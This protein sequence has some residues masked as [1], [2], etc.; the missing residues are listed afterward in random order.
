MRKASA[1]ALESCARALCI[2][3]QPVFEVQS[4]D[5]ACGPSLET[6]PMQTSAV[7]LKRSLQ[8]RIKMLSLDS[9]EMQ[10]HDCGLAE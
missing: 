8:Q 9:A 6:G 10:A 7:Q 2:Q 5:A 1:S 3:L 4:Q